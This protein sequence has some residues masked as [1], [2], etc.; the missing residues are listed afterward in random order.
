MR[1]HL[2]SHTD[3]QHG[4]TLVSHELIQHGAHP[5]GVELFHCVVEMSYAGQD[6]PSRIRELRRPRRT[7][8]RDVESLVQIQEC[9]DVSQAIIDNCEGHFSSATRSALVPRATGGH[10]DVHGI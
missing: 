8:C 6:E 1:K 4:H 3:S 9:M 7:A 10:F 5:G 2:H